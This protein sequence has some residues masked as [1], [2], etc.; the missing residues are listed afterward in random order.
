MDFILQVLVDLPHLTKIKKIIDGE[1]LKQENYSMKLEHG[2]VGE[3]NN[4]Q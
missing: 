4:E 3:H 1:E 2:G